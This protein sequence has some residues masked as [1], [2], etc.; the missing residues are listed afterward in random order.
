MY[1]L[2]FLAALGVAAFLV[3][4]VVNGLVGLLSGE[5]PRDTGSLVVDVFLRMMVVLE[6]GW[7]GRI[8]NYCGFT[9]RTRKLAFF[10]GLLCVF[11]FL[12]RGCHHGHA[13]HVYTYPVPPQ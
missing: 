12:L 8:L 4:W 9:G 1:D 3:A 7:F 10:L 5:K 2:A 6:L 13:G 11:V